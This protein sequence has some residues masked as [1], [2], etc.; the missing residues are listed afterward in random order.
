MRPAR[1]TIYYEEYAPLTEDKKWDPQQNRKVSTGQGLVPTPMWQTAKLGGKTATVKATVRPAVD[2][3]RLVCPWPPLLAISK[4]A[5]EP[6]KASPTATARP[7]DWDLAERSAT[8]LDTTTKRPALELAGCMSASVRGE[9][10]TPICIL[11]KFGNS[12]T[13]LPWQRLQ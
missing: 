6:F 5:G 13:I 1:K 2:E 10:R 7:P 12:V 4:S 11:M 8:R 9:V 3:V